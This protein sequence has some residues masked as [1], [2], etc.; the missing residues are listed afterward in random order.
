MLPLVR[1]LFRR[2]AVVQGKSG[3][4]RDRPRRGLPEDEAVRIALAVTHE[5][6]EKMGRGLDR[7]ERMPAPSPEEVRKRREERRKREDAEDR[8]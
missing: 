4:R 8:S 1:A 5:A 7:E 2:V 6:R 3:D